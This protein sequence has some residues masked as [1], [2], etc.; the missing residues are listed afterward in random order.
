[1]L[2]GNMI[3]PDIM[4]A[5]SLCGHGSQILIA[6]G[7]YPLKARTSPAAKRVYLGLTPGLPTVTDVLKALLSVS[8][9]EAARVM[10]TEDGGEPEI[11]ADFRALLPEIELEKTEKNAFYAACCEPMVELVISTG[12]KRTYANILLTVGCS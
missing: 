1:M 11:F 7:N 9:F 10:L 5:L 6:D 3:N 4:Q 12:E 2:K 8:N